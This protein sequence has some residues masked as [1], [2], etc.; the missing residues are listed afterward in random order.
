[1][2]IV[3]QFDQNL[4]TLLKRL[5]GGLRP[6]MELFSFLGEPIMVLSVGFSAF[7]LSLKYNHPG[8]QHA[9]FYSLIAFILSVGLKLLL[10]RRRPYGAV[11]K[12]LG[13]QS[14]SFPSGHAFGTVIFYGQLAYLTA[15]H[16]V[17]PWNMIITALV[18]LGIF[19]VG[20]SRV[21]LNAHYPSD[22]VAGWIL[23][24]IS[25]IIIN[26]LAY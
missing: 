2:I 9:L 5:P 8:V 23:G 11:I 22:V 1:M 6:L 20:V 7:V 24:G 25:L 13:V 4:G 18:W 21:Y 16:L 14:Y 15:N 19:M 26:A 17:H 10:H 3:R 12:T